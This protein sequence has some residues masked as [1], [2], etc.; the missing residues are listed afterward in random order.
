MCRSAYSPYQCAAI[1]RQKG[2]PAIA[3]CI[4]DFSPIAYTIHRTRKKCQFRHW[5]EQGLVN[6]GGIWRNAKREKAL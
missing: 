5:E 1:N 6:V 4:Y 2:Q 3:N